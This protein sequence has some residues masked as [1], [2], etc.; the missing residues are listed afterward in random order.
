M[1]QTFIR[2]CKFGRLEMNTFLGGFF[3]L[4][5]TVLKFRHT[6][7][8]KIDQNAKIS[9]FFSSLS[10]LKCVCGYIQDKNHFFF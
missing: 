5:R 6:R 1:K 4:F 8:T 3:L 10:S 2:E 7:K 9:I